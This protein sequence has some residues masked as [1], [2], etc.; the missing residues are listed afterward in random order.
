[1]LWDRPDVLKRYFVRIRIIFFVIYLFVML[2]GQT[3]HIDVLMGHF[4][5]III[6]RRIFNNSIRKNNY[7]SGERALK[8]IKLLFKKNYKVTFTT[9]IKKE[10]NMSTIV[11]YVCSI[12]IIYLFQFMV[13]TNFERKQISFSFFLTEYWP[14]VSDDDCPNDLCKKGQIP[15]C[16]AGLCKCIPAR[17]GPWQRWKILCARMIF[18]AKPKKVRNCS[19]RI[20]HKLS[21]SYFVS[22]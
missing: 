2:K 11:N 7:L 8:I 4:V 13:A 5:I 9:K 14:C 22:T 1:M 3:W 10:G 6:L 20:F 19:A 21:L 16:V 15:K 17:F 12:I 18:G